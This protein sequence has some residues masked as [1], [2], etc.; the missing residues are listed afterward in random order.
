MPRC[1]RCPSLRPRRSCHFGEK[2]VFRYHSGCSCR[3]MADAQ[4]AQIKQRQCAADDEY[5]V[6]WEAEPFNEDVS[7]LPKKFE[8]ARIEV[9]V[10]DRV[11]QLQQSERE[12]GSKNHPSKADIE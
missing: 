7:G 9:A 3:A 10:L 2:Y 5:D 1:G 8:R 11:V 12:E 6:T 4:P